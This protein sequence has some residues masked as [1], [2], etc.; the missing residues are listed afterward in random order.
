RACRTV[1]PS[2]EGISDLLIGEV[3]AVEPL[4]AGLAV[5]EKPHR[6]AL[7]SGELR[8]VRGAGRVVADEREDQVGALGDHLLVA[9]DAGTLAE[10]A[11]Q[12]G[13]PL[14]EDQGV[15]AVPADP[16]VSDLIGA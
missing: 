7:L 6:D 8:A 3:P 9:D 4:N 10:L 16:L 5:P 12:G 13:V 1:R 2:V 15:A 11:P 14:G